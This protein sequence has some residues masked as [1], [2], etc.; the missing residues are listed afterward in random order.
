MLTAI[1]VL[2]LLDDT[3]F[4]LATAWNARMLESVPTGFAFDERHTP[5]ITLLQ[6]Y[7]HSE[8]LDDVYDAVGATVAAFPVTALELTV[9]ELTYT[10]DPATPGTATASLSVAVSPVVIDLHAALID[11]TRPHTGT[12]GTAAAF[13][14]NDHE[15]DIDPA[16]IEYVEDFVPDHSG[17]DFAAHITVGRATVDDLTVLGAEP[18][19]PLAV[20]PPAIAVYQLG[21]HG[22]AQIELRRWPAS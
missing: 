1:D 9:V 16:T 17:V 11:A 19:E 13:A 12:G 2:M 6:R 7:V 20:R 10:E 3:T 5:H 22:T 18:L 8:R 21:N 4:D 14:T 15:P